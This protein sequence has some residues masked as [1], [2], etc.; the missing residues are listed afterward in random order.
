M[1]GHELLESMAAAVLVSSGLVLVP[2]ASLA[3]RRRVAGLATRGS[4]ATDLALI[5]ALAALGVAMVLWVTATGPVA[6]H[7]H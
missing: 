1:H 6:P 5:A 7:P 3:R 4:R 2:R